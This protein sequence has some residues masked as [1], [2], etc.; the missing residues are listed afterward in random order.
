MI[1]QY[2]L[3]TTCCQAKPEVVLTP[4]AMAFYPQ[5]PCAAWYNT[6]LIKLLPVPNVCRCFF[7]AVSEAAIM[8]LLLMTLGKFPLKLV[9]A[10]LS[11]KSWEWGRTQAQC[12]QP[13]LPV[14]AVQ[15]KS[16]STL[17]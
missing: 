12:S 10:H 15:N 16:D 13:A 14:V 2:F 17:T 11:Y 8:T 5:E 1:Y 9:Q 7:P 3:K 4:P 6:A